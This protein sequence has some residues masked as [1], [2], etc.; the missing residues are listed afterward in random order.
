MEAEMGSLTGV[1]IDFAMSHL[2]F[3][4]L[5]GSILG[6]LGLAILVTRRQTIA[7]SG[8]MWRETF[9][10]MD[11]PRFFGTLALLVIYF[12][13]MEPVGSLWPNT[14]LGFLLCSVPFVFLSGV[15]F[16]HHRGPRALAVLALISVT[17]PS[18]IWWLFAEVF[19]LTLP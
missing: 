6:L 15:I 13:L 11:K 9:S 5:I 4:K 14:G 7:G 1:S 2:V 16:M 8:A 19:F 18:L 12:F 3:P 17:I 10:E